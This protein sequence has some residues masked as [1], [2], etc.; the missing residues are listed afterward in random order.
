MAG[1]YSISLLDTVDVHVIKYEFVQ[2]AQKRSQV[3][4]KTSQVLAIRG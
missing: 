1:I 3:L 4:Y 2:T